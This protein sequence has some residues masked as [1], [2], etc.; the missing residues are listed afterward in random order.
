MW[1]SVRPHRPASSRWSG[2]PQASAPPS[3]RRRKAVQVLRLLCLPRRPFP[4]LQ[5]AGLPPTPA[6][7]RPGLAEYHSA[8]TGRAVEALIFRHLAV[9][10]CTGLVPPFFAIS[11]P[12]TASSLSPTPS[13]Q[14]F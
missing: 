10:V 11:P 7:S 14:H 12:F 2:T 13:P 6:G 1:V 4:P 5:S 3:L 8:P 9:T